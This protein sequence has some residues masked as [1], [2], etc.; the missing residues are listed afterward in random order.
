M[1]GKLPRENE[2]SKHVFNRFLEQLKKYSFIKMDDNFHGLPELLANIPP[3]FPVKSFFLKSVW[4]F[5]EG[6]M[7]YAFLKEFEAHPSIKN[8][9]KLENRIEDIKNEI[10][11]ILPELQENSS[12]L[13]RRS[14]TL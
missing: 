1:I 13:K 5:D 7:L 10:S 14:T 12:T 9:P 2:F 3:D 4:S 6:S 8:F 11:S